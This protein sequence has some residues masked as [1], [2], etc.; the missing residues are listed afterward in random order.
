MKVVHITHSASGGAGKAAYNLHVGLRAM[1]VDSFF[2]TA[3]LDKARPHAALLPASSPGGNVSATPDFDRAVA[4]WKALVDEYPDRVRNYEMFSSPEGMLPRLREAI[5]KD[6]DILHLHWVSG[7]VP[8]DAPQPWLERLPVVW[9]LHDMNPFTGGCHFSAGCE[10]YRN[11]CGDCPQ[12]NSGREDDHSRRILEQKRLSY[13]GLGITCVSPSRWMDRCAARSAVLRDTHRECIANGIDLDTFRRRPEARER[14]G[15]FPSRDF[16]LLFGADQAG[17]RKGL[18]KLREG[19]AVL[20]ERGEARNLRLATFGAEGGAIGRETGIPEV[21]FGYITNPERLAEI[22]SMADCL[23][24]PSLE[25]NLPG[26]AIEALAC[27]TPTV[28]FN[29]GGMAD[30][31]EHGRTGYLAEPHRAENLANGV[32]W[33]MEQAAGRESVAASCRE[34]AQRLFDRRDRAQD[35]ADL[36]Q[37]IAKERGNSRKARF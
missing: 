25:D 3:R 27:G 7:I 1:G 36:Y 8:F 13:A 31:V 4:A 5:P 24:V 22:Y 34:R 20:A 30:V 2:L 17:G 11:R 32:A 16:V 29:V 9:T 19:L 14:D 26:V 12:L 23:A 15:R 21:S 37:R 10:R 35:M 6:T 33:A 18:A 28:A